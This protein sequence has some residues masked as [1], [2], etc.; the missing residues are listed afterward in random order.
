MLAGLQI[1]VGYFSVAATAPD[2]VASGPVV[3]AGRTRAF[4]SPPVPQATD[5]TFSV[6][7]PTITNEI[8]LVF[9]GTRERSTGSL[10]GEIVPDAQ[11]RV[12]GLVPVAFFVVGGLIVGMGGIFVP[13]VS[14]ERPTLLPFV[15]AALPGAL[16]I[17]WTRGC[18]A[19]VHEA[20][21]NVRADS[22]REHLVWHPGFRWGARRPAS[23]P[24]PPGA[25]GT[26]AGSSGGKGRTDRSMRSAWLELGGLF[27]PIVIVVVLIVP[28][29]RSGDERADWV[30][31]PGVAG[32]E[33][34]ADHRMV[35]YVLPD[36]REQT[37]TVPVMRTVEFGEVIDLYYPPGQ[38]QLIEQDRSGFVLPYFV[39]GGFAAIM[40]AVVVARF[41]IAVRRARRG[42]RDG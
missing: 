13:L 19:A 7:P 29:L 41:S 37:S 42:R 26:L 12:L 39:F 28:W 21:R 20:A 35:T 22:P 40:T 5:I 32:E 33:V 14:G 27:V 38:P 4:A 6:R 16:M 17:V 1:L 34:D 31:V 15:W 2:H 25:G 9:R 8:W 36:G 23:P 10:T 24:P 11:M 3:S 18:G 30:R